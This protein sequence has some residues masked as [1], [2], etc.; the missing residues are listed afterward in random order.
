[1]GND[2]AF[3]LGWDAA[4][5]IRDRAEVNILGVNQR[6]QA[7]VLQHGGQE[8]EQLHAS[9]AFSDTHPL[10]WS[11]NSVHETL[12]QLLETAAQEPGRRRL[13]AKCHPMQNEPLSAIERKHRVDFSIRTPGSSLH[14][15]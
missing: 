2:T 13:W 1:M 7:E 10:S 15:P 14:K 8:Q 11:D 4:K 12:G 9:Q 5:P 6:L 3:V